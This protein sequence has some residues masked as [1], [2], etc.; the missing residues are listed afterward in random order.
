MKESYRQKPLLMLAA[1]V[2]A[3]A[4]LLAGC[5][6]GST[7]KK[8]TKPQMVDLSGLAAD[9]MT[10]AGTL[11]LKAGASGDIGEVTF[12]CA[13]GGDDCAVTVTV[14]DGKAA[15]SATGGMVT[16]KASAAYA[17]RKA[18]A[19]TALMAKLTKEAGTMEKAIDA[20]AA[21][22]TDGGPGGTARTDVNG[23][24]TAD[25]TSDDQYK[26]AIER[27][28]SGTTITVTDPDMNADDDPKFMSKD[29]MLV[30]TMEADDD[31]NVVMEKMMVTTDIGAPKAVPFAKFE[32]VA[33]NG[34][35]TTPQTL[36]YDPDTTTDADDDGTA[37]ND[38]TGLTVNQAQASVLKLVNAGAFSAGTSAVLTFPGDN[39][40]TNTKDEAFETAGTYNGSSGTYRCTN[41]SDTNCTVSIDGDG[42]I[43]AMSSGWVF[44]PAEGATTDQPDYDYLH[45]GF[46]LKSTTDKDGVLT[47][48][49]V[50]TFAGSSMNASDATE[51]SAVEGSATYKG[52]ATGVYVKNVYKNDGSLAS[53]T[54]GH[55][56]ANASLMVNF[57]GNDVAANDKWT[58][59][60]TIGNF[61]LSGS[62]KE[63]N[64][65]VDLEGTT[66]ENDANTGGNNTFSGTT[67]GGAAEAKFN[68][69]FY[70][71][72]DLDTS[73]ETNT[74]DRLAPGAVAGEFN[75]NFNNG[76]VAGGFGARKE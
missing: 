44:T 57:G 59:T 75:A 41:N 40:A 47:Y 43:S 34:D 1:G 16:A 65:S 56:T 33:A 20:E 14:T 10:E 4:L 11:D 54:S 2:A 31:G 63:N 52:G 32:V 72:T 18:D 68:G 39:S 21:Q 5:G 55:F 46:W 28:S 42:A 70:G 36:N 66:G 26:I 15:A 37:D 7:V 23:T 27:D 74:T 53:A 71:L 48:D 35:K 61:M 69:M 49:E 67:D 64:W 13:A 30:R 25:D 60:G 45:Y 50:E 29:G 9:V 8:D 73:T 51:M 3:V 38:F 24:T 58:V 19:Q 6:G 12:T 76:A 62:D 17:K 22:E